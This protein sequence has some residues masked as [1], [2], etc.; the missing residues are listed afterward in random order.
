MVFQLGSVVC[1]SMDVYQTSHA[2]DLYESLCVFY[3]VTKVVKAE[4]CDS[5]TRRRL[6]EA[7][8]FK[9]LS[10]LLRTGWCP[11]IHSLMHHNIIEI[12]TESKR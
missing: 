8:G 2:F 10:R 6:F 11:Q 5:E 7:T 3:K 1:S 12:E 9:F 4:E